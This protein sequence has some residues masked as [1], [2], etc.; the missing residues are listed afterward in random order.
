[1]ITGDHPRTAAAIATELGIVS[2]GTATALTGAELDRISNADLQTTVRDCSVY[3]RVNPEHKLRIV[4]ALQANGEVVAM[5]GDGVNDAP[6]LKTADIGVAMGITGTDVAKEAAG[7]VLADDNRP[8]AHRAPSRRRSARPSNLSAY[9]K[10]YGC[11]FN[12]RSH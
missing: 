2:A 5:I 12:M 4:R 11:A 9:P 6:A 10:R 3:A 1:M 8:A 7:M